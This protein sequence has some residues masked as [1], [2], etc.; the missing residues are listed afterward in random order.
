ML[1]GFH[2]EAIPG[3]PHTC[4]IA[5]IS[6][7]YIRCVFYSMT[8]AGQL[9]NLYLEVVNVLFILGNIYSRVRFI[10]SFYVANKYFIL[11]RVCRVHSVFYL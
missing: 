7:E 8:R 1:I 10:H 4:Y 11:F 6:D 5:S 3:D 9:D 2:C